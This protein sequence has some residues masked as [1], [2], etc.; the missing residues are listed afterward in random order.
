VRPT[1]SKLSSV[2][3]F[4]QKSPP[5]IGF[6]RGCRRTTHPA[7]ISKRRPCFARWCNELDPGCLIYVGTRPTCA[8]KS[9]S[10][11]GCRVVGSRPPGPA[12]YGHMSAKCIQ[13]QPWVSPG[14]L[15]ILRAC[16]G[17]R[18]LSYLWELIEQQHSGRSWTP[19]QELPLNLHLWGFPHPRVVSALRKASCSDSAGRDG[20]PLMSCV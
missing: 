17:C 3:G 7:S 4:S 20:I 18:V 11:N 15:P 10:R 5:F 12:G 13:K 2:E 9:P 8:K 1:R 16:G 6:L 19:F 14:H